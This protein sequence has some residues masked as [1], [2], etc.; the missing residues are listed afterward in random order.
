MLET[1]TITEVTA[2]ARDALAVASAAFG[3]A[4]RDHELFDKLCV[5]SC[6]KLVGLLAGEEG[7][8]LK[9]FRTEHHDT[10]LL[11]SGLLAAT[12]RFAISLLLTR[13]HTAVSELREA[14]AAVERLEADMAAVGD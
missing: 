6:C 1:E 7:G 4:P 3:E 13:S 2:A 9:Q 5:E 10:T 11:T 12:L 14:L 8:D